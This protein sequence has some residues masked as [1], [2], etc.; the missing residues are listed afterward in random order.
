MVPRI[1]AF[2][3]SPDRTL[4][5]RVGNAGCLIKY[6]PPKG[7]WPL[8]TRMSGRLVFLLRDVHTPSQYHGAGPGGRGEEDSYR[9]WHFFC[10]RIIQTKVTSHLVRQRATS[11]AGAKTK[12]D[13]NRFFH[14][15]SKMVIFCNRSYGKGTCPCYLNGLVHD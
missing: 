11:P 13:G 12:I 5:G 1:P 8:G 15:L 14:S 6:L 7:T 9:A 4:P 2:Q 3:I 10:I